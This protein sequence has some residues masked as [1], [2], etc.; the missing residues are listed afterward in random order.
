LGK[1]DACVRI[2]QYYSTTTHN[3][4]AS[5]HIF[6]STTTGLAP[7][8]GK[9]WIAA[10]YAMCALSQVMIVRPR[11]AWCMEA[12]C[13]FFPLHA[14]WYLAVACP[15]LRVSAAVRHPH[16]YWTYLAA[17][18]R[19][20]CGCSRRQ[21]VK[22]AH[23]YQTHGVLRLSRSSSVCVSRCQIQQS[24]PDQTKPAIGGAMIIGSIR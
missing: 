2:T 12:C 21:P 10:A 15:V 3:P 9:G 5:R 17:P 22:S 16:N 4:Q 7:C 23:A 18:L 13:L 19:C 11:C 6:A 14:S 20:C 24:R 8:L 1:M